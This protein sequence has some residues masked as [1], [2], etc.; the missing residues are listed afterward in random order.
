MYYAQC[1][2][3]GYA[4]NIM[5]NRIEVP[6]LKRCSAVPRYN[7]RAVEKTTGLSPRTLRSWERRYGLPAPQR[8]TGGRRLYSERDLALI[9]WLREQ[10]A[11]GVAIGRAVAMLGEESDEARH[12][13]PVP[14]NLERLQLQLLQAFDWMNEEEATGTLQIALEPVPLESVI[15]DLIQPVL[16]RVGELWATG[17]MS[18]ASEH[19]GTQVVR[20]L[21]SDLLRRTDPPSRPQ[22]VL[23]GSAPGEEHDLGALVLALLLRRAGFRVTYLGPNLEAESLRADLDRI[24]PNALCLSA[25]TQ[26]A[27]GALR[28][29]YSALGASYSGIL[30]YGGSAFRG[31]EE[32]SVPGLHLHGT[33]ID[34]VRQLTAAL[35][36][37]G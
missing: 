37:T 14:V 29:L 3:S 21:L 2:Q 13:A 30:A 31:E 27:A 12:A 26:T 25:T 6:D 24:R 23:V 15:L 4:L 10:V 32:P 20:G 22:H 35:D 18:V 19:F 11:R 5:D 28:D 16:N 7:M 36:A 17:R 9:R 33:V 34:A 8:D 1:M